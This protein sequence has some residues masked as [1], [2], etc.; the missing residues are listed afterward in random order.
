M[1]KSFEPVTRA[2]NCF[3]TSGSILGD[4]R[5]EKCY[6]EII[7]RMCK[8]ETNVIH[9][10]SACHAEQK[11]YY[12]FMSND[13][14]T[15]S[16]LMA[17]VVKPTRQKVEDRHVLVPSD[18]TE[19]ALKSQVSHIKDAK[20]LGVL[21][22]N[23]TPG[24]LFHVSMAIDADTKRALGISDLISWMRAPSQA[25]R[26][27]KERSKKQRSWE[28]KESYKWN[29]GLKNSLE[30]LQPARMITFIFDAEGDF[31]QMWQSI[32]A[33]NAQA[34]MRMGRDWSF[35]AEG[36]GAAQKA[37]QYMQ[38]EDWAGTYELPLRAQNRRNGSRRNEQK[39]AKRKATMQVRYRSLR[40]KSLGEKGPQLYLVEAKE[41]PQSVPEGESPVH[42]YLLTTHPVN[43]LEDAMQIIGWYQLRWWIEQLFRV[44]KQQ[45]FDIEHT[46]LQRVEAILRQAILSFKAAFRVMQLLLARGKEQTQPLDEVFSP[47]EIQCLEALNEKYQGSTEKLKNP[48][49]PDQLSWATWI[50]GRLGGWKGLASQT[51]P[52]PIRLKRGLEKF[53]AIFE[54]WMFFSMN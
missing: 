42:W 15:P 27:E 23:Q 33:H 52:G 9:R 51:P 26:R 54:G 38:A 28:Q 35:E 12:R 16:A 17:K 36:G 21:S 2:A 24:F 18:T 13:N 19:V 30:V 3:T 43:S 11:S 14:I 4:L 29:L 5:R 20:K 47:D 34:V 41:Q 6:E 46:E 45:G 44:V 31:S 8:R 53:Y 39:R 50:I 10:F 48:Y 49:P 7:E 32:Q 40:L 22:D 37:E 1:A 25:S